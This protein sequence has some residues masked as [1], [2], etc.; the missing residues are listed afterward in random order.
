MRTSIWFRMF[1]NHQVY[2]FAMFIDTRM[3]CLFARG[4]NLRVRQVYCHGGILCVTQTVWAPWIFQCLYH[5]FYPCFYHGFY[6]LS[7]IVY[8]ISHVLPMFSNVFIVFSHVRILS[9]NYRSGG[10]QL[11]ATTEVGPAT[12]RKNSRLS[13]APTRWAP[14]NQLGK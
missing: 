5:G 13:S 2:Q 8:P 4:G 9:F 14:E 7:H 6:T 3:L 1:L 11:P 12:R 10:F